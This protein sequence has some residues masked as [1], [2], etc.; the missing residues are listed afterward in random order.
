MHI[1]HGCDAE[2]VLFG[3]A[4]DS[5]SIEEE[6][7]GTRRQYVAFMILKWN[8]GDSNQEDNMITVDTGFEV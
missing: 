3:S 6:Y 5:G 7:N 1:R 4:Q 8:K 2:P